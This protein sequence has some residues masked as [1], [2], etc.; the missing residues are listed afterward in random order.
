[1]FDND[2]LWA[3]CCWNCSLKPRESLCSRHLSAVQGYS[4]IW[5][6]VGEDK[7]S[8]RCHDVPVTLKET[9]T[10]C[11]KRP[12][13]VRL[14]LGS[15]NLIVKTQKILLQFTR[16]ARQTGVGQQR[17]VQRK[18]CVYF[19]IK[20]QPLANNRRNPALKRI[21]H[22]SIEY[23]VGTQFRKLSTTVARG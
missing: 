23:C 11:D 10:H 16:N 13:N 18:I 19:Q 14:L 7:P 20:K 6:M 2:W 17:V 1:M 9:R 22:H 15:E 3:P 5:C 8:S 4:S 12:L 21:C